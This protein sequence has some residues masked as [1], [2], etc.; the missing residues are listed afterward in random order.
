VGHS[1]GA[2]EF[3]SSGGD[4]QGSHHTNEGLADVTLR[5]VIEHALIVVPGLVPND[6]LDDLFEFARLELSLPEALHIGGY[7]LSEGLVTSNRIPDR[8][9]ES[10]E[11]ERYNPSGTRPTDQ[12]KVVAGQGFCVKSLLD[13]DP[14][15]D[16]AQYDEF[17]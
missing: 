4:V 15:H 8:H 14:V 17:R 5:S 13:F 11:H 9:P 3:R 6:P 1:V 16:L 10:A 7:F 12:I 2:E